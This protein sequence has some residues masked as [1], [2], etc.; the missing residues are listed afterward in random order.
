MRS[1]GVD[2]LHLESRQYGGRQLGAQRCIEMQ[3]RLVPQRRMDWPQAGQD[4]LA[5]SVA[6]A[7]DVQPPVCSRSPA[8][9]SAIACQSAMKSWVRAFTAIPAA[10]WLRSAAGIPG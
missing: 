5:G 1:R 10:A 8:T 3:D 4:Q 9:S 2:L 6:G 7:P